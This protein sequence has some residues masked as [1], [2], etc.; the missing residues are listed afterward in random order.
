M[1]LSGSLRS[2]PSVL[3]V[4]FVMT[5]CSSTRI[6]PL[7]FDYY[8]TDGDPS[9]ASYAAN[10]AP[11]SAPARAEIAPIVPIGGGTSEPVVTAPTITIQK[12][13]SLYA[14]SRMHL[15]SGKRWREIAQ[16]NGLSDADVTRLS[17]G[18]V[19]KLPAR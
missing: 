7:E 6:D 5:A 11:A 18:R 2:V 17:V 15:G 1:V 9:T 16:L 12:G 3:A 19:L 8:S 13:D 4:A 10:P 14:L